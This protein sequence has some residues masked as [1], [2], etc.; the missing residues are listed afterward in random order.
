MSVFFSAKWE[1]LSPVATLG[2]M[3]R[4][5]LSVFY[6]LAVNWVFVVCRIL[7]QI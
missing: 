1:Y 7:V 2:K 3:R 5:Q 6:V 4:F